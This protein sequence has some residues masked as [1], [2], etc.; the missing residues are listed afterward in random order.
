MTGKIQEIIKLLDREYPGV[1]I[2]LNYSNLLELLVAAMLS[3]QCTDERVNLVTEKLFK[4]YKTAEDY[5][6]ANIQELENDIRSAGFYRNKARNLIAACKI[7]VEQFN[8][9]VPLTMHELTK[10]P[11]IGR[12]TANVVLAGYG[13]NE[14]IAVDTHVARVS[15]RIGLTENS[16]PLKIERDLMRI[17]PREN[18]ERF[19]L[20]LI[21]HGRAI[22]NA[23]R[24]KCEICIISKFC[25]YFN[26]KFRLKQ[27]R[28]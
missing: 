12:K 7:I 16:N 15:R 1:K 18:W 4:K 23:R 24:P 2:T 21:Y 25:D 19:S 6:R 5:A 10:L 20:L 14:G 27:S 22:C 9:R 17:V 13:K 8:S 26:F 11:G 3:A 28:A